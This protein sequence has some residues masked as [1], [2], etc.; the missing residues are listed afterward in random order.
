MS[1]NTQK[2]Q[3]CNCFTLIFLRYLQVLD[4]LLVVLVDM[5]QFAHCCVGFYCCLLCLL[6]RTY[7]YIHARTAIRAAKVQKKSHICKKIAKYSIKKIRFLIIT[8]IFDYFRLR[9]YRV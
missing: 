7:M 2:L 8:R 9:G 3:K 5:Y 6:V 4:P 1:K